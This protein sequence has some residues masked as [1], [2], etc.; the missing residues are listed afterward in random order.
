MCWYLSVFLSYPAKTP[1]VLGW[2]SNILRSVNVMGC[3]WQRIPS[4]LQRRWKKWEECQTLGR[5]N[6]LSNVRVEAAEPL[7]NGLHPELW[8]Q[9]FKDSLT[10][11]T[12][13]IIKSLT[14]MLGTWK[15]GLRSWLYVSTSCDLLQRVCFSPLFLLLPSTLLLL[16]HNT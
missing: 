2:K 13:T 9:K 3:R 12:K 1:N 15:L 11:K 14:T 10:T 8:K 5:T 16:W 7:D 6:D 4:E